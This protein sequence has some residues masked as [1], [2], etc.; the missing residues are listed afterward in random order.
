M[1]KDPT[2]VLRDMSIDPLT[3]HTTDEASSRN[4]KSNLVSLS[5]LQSSFKLKNKYLKS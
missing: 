1:R 2:D 3:Q 5:R 4:T